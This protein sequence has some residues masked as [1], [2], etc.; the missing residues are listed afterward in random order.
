MQVAQVVGILSFVVEIAYARRTR[1]LRFA[2]GATP[3]AT[4]GR[5]CA[6]SAQ[7]TFAAEHVC[8]AT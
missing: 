8:D 4:V 7:A 5:Q 1:A 2:S 6:A 3:R